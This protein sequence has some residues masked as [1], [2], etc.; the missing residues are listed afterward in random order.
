MT[1][2]RSVVLS[3][4]VSVAALIVLTLGASAAPAG[5]RTAAAQGSY[6][7]ASHTTAHNTSSSAIKAFSS[8]HKISPALR[9]GANDSSARRGAGIQ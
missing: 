1:S 5:V 6:L 8:K 2:A 4:L 9:P 3:L 7:S